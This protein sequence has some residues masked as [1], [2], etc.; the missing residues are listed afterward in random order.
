MTWQRLVWSPRGGDWRGHGVA[1]IGV[2]TV[3]FDWVV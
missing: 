2:G 1:E 3:D